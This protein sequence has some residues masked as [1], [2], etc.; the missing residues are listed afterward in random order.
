MERL[1][2]G[3]HPLYGSE[4][5]AERESP[6]SASSP[7]HFFLLLDAIAAQGATTRTS[8]ADPPQKNHKSKTDD[9]YY[10]DWLQKYGRE[11]AELIKR[12]VA[13]NVEHY[14]YLRQFA[15]RLSP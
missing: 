8:H 6:V 2:R 15:I 1:P 12:T 10:A 9:D 11:G 3:R 5:E 13:E 4:A 7:S 14:E